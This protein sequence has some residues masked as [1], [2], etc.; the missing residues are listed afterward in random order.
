[1]ISLID[2]SRA[3]GAARA[4]KI[5]LDRASLRVE[6]FE[7]VGILAPSGSGKTTLA[8]IMAGLETPDSGLVIRSGTLS[9]PIG[10]SSS[11]HPMLSAAENVALI[12]RLWNLDRDDYLARVEDFCELGRAFH[13]PVADFSPGMRNQLG[14]ALSLCADFDTYL[15]D[16]M[17]SVS[18]PGYRDKCD[19]ALL[20]RGASSTMIFLSR[21]ARVIK[22]YA[23]TVYVL[24][25][26]QLVLCESAEHADDILTY[27]QSK[28]QP[29]YALI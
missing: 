6:A 15:A 9:W 17:S 29:D 25:G 26:G 12:A 13:G 2:V 14:L 24:C 28:E 27:V 11:F 18:A 3:V 22:Q 7:H 4:P 23:A 5:I 20:D 21:H 10:F 16:D 8:R 1:M 19:A